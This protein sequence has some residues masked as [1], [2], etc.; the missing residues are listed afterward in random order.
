MVKIQVAVTL[1]ITDKTSL[2]EPF[3]LAQEIKL[4]SLN[5][6]PLHGIK[7]NR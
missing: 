5:C 2:E 6:E 1:S 3:F 4:S 7:L